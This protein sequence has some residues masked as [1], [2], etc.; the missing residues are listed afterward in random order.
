MDRKEYL[1]QISNNAKPVKKSGG[2]PDFV[3]SKIFWVIIGVLGLAVII[4]IIGGVLSGSK[5]D[6]PQDR[7]YTLLLRI[8][9]TRSIVDEYQVDVK[10]STLR[11]YGTSLSSILGNTSSQLTS[12]V[13]EVYKYKPKNV[14]EK[15]QTTATENAD[16]LNNELFVAKINA[17]LDNIFDLKMVHEI[18]VITNQ[19]ADILNT[20][21]NEDIIGILSPSLDSL[22][23]LYDDFN[24]WTIDK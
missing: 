20:T 12:Y 21:K 15:I 7:L 1:N 13:T 14:P 22:T 18:A 16:E 8:D 19:E 9:N 3:H 2:L 17:D 10:N 6:T 4:M 23:N 24:E 5:K 11:G